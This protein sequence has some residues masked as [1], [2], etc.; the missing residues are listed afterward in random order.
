[1]QTL[2]C[3]HDSLCL[4]GVHMVAKEIRVLCGVLSAVARCRSAFC[5][6]PGSDIDDDVGG[7]GGVKARVLN[8][9]DRS[10]EGVESRERRN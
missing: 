8:T 6:Q 9:W 10:A 5:S 1:M 4:S 3:T 7:V 2:P